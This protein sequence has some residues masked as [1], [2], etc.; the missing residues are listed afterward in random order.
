MSLLRTRRRSLPLLAAAVVGTTAVLLPLAAGHADPTSTANPGDAGRLMLVLDSSGSMSDPASGGT[1]KI[2]AAKSALHEVVDGLPA[3]AEVGMRVYGAKVFS[4]SD[5]GACTDSQRVVDLGSD[6]RADLDSAIDA[7]TPYGET[8]IGYALQQADADLGGEG[9]RSI[10]LVSDGEPTCPPDPCQVARQINKDGGNVRIDVVGLDVDGKAEA[11]LRCIADKG[12]GTYYDADSADDLSAAL[13]T[14]ATRAVRPYQPSG[15]P[16]TG[17]ADPTSAP[18][19]APGSYV[20]QIGGIETT[21]GTLHYKVERSIPGSSIT[22]AA[23]ILTPYYVGRKHRQDEWDRIDLALS[24]TDGEACD[25]ADP[26][27]VR[28][29]DATALT[30]T[31][32]AGDC[33][34]ADELVARV[35]RTGGADFT[36]PLELVVAE[37]PPV[38][39]ATTLPEGVSGAVAWKAPPKGPDAGSVTGGSSF[40]ESTPIS[41][42]TYRGTIVPG[43]VQSFDVEVGWGQQLAATMTIPD[44]S[45]PLAAE[46]SQQ[47]SPFGLAVYSP[48][49]A[50]AVAVSDGA[51]PH[52][53]TIYPTGG[54][55]VGAVTAPVTYR[56]REV[57]GDPLRAAATAGGYTIVLSLADSRARTSYEVPFVLRVGVTGDVV[58]AP[59][60]DLAAA[61]PSESPSSESAS[62]SPTEEPATDGPA[63][64]AESDAEDSDVPVGLLV[65]GGALLVVVGVGGWLVNR[66]IRGS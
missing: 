2:E 42:G 4:R 18:T 25:T 30:V 53:S 27:D 29:M 23:T 28:S 43:E 52:S 41:P 48:Y 14:L 38:L 33:P 6:N 12:N 16:V 50:D 21:T 19:L 45:G 39:D 3:D 7:Y 9:P 47:G 65:I 66:R 32:D 20:D 59:E 24:T 40:A 49:R 64:T 55:Q 36:T 5:A 22:V 1:T 15:E 17:S 35:T 62:S 56:N 57:V 51:P 58:A 44:P 46:L 34:D 60:Y 63:A 8:P 13:E 37:E 26:A 61:E 54:G 10:V 11:A 31:V